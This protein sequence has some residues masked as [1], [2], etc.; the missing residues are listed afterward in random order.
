MKNEIKEP[1]TSEHGKFLSN[2][3]DPTKEDAQRHLVYSHHAMFNGKA[4]REEEWQHHLDWINTHV[5]GPPKGTAKY[6]VAELTK[7][8]MIGIYVKKKKETSK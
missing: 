8:G 1:T 3:Y 2:T 7:M 6:S 4:A 5:T